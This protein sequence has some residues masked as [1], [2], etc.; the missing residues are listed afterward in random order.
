MQ[1]SSSAEIVSSPPTEL[2]ERVAALMGSTPTGWLRASGGYTIAERWT[3]DLADGQRVFA[4]MATT[5]DLGHRLKDEYR[6]MLAAP[7]ELRCQVLGWEA[8]KRPLLLVEDFSHGRWPPP[9]E[10]GDVERVLAGLNVLW[11]TPAPDFFKSAE[12][13]RKTF[14]GWQK[15]AV[16]PSGFL[17][18]GFCSPAWLERALPRLVEAE[19]SAFL[20]GNDFVHFD[21]RGDNL[22]FAGER[23]VLVDWNFACRGPRDLDLVLWLPSLR[24]EGGP[25]PDDLIGDV[26]EYVAAWS[27][28]FANGASQPPPRGAPTVRHF[29]KRQLRIALP[30]AA[31]ALGLPE[32]D[33]N[34]AQAE[35]DALRRAF[36]LGDVTQGE[37]RLARDEVERDAELARP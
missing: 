7:N 4:K 21:I 34:W 27:G 16:D 5:D 29:Q 33:L 19:R 25:L 14:S 8:G 28:V 20:D 36:E 35:T 32:P 11:D 22:C 3:L 13:D 6:N 18:L 9:W 2:L 10:P 12:R 37:W 17:S 24:L 30:W 1:P 31:R 15:L 26:P 23:V